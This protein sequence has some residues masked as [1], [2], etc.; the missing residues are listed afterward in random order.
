MSGVGT[1]VLIIAFWAGSGVSTQ[2]VP[3]KNHKACEREKNSRLDELSREFV[4]KSSSG[5][6]VVSGTCFDLR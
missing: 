5:Q 4:E 2:Q 3:F 6:M 1:A